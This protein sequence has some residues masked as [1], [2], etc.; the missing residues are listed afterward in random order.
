MQGG[1]GNLT[2]EVTEFVFIMMLK[3]KDNVTVE[4]IYKELGLSLHAS[5]VATTTVSVDHTINMK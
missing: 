2:L 4:N 3:A 1:R 5:T